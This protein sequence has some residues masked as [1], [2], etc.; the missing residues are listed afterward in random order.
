MPTER[1]DSGEHSQ[2]DALVKSALIDA[3]AESDAPRTP[4][5]APTPPKPVTSID[6]GDPLLP[7]PDLTGFTLSPDLHA[8]PFDPL[9]IANRGGPNLLLRCCFPKR[10]HRAFREVLRT[11]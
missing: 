6:G 7:R 1:L 5:S 2:L 4:T 3:F 8:S 9:G 11:A 10:R